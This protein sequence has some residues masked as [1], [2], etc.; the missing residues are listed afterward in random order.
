[1]K[2]GLFTLIVVKEIEEQGRVKEF[3]DIISTR[4]ESL[5]RAVVDPDNQGPLLELLKNTLTLNLELYSDLTG[6]NYDKR[7]S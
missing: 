4:I 1:M 3:T 6:E 5:R 7:Y 2:Q